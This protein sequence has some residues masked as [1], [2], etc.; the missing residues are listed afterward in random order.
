[1]KLTLNLALKADGKELIL[2]KRIKLLKEIDKTGSILQAAKN[3]P[4]SYKTAWDS[5]D[6]M[7]NLS[8]EVLVHSKAGGR[9]GGGTTLSEYGKNLI[10][11]Y[12]QIKEAQNS[13][14]KTLSE[15]V[16]LNSGEIENLERIAM[17]ISAR[18]VFTGK[19]KKITEGMVNAE[20]V[21]ELKD[22]V[23]ISSVITKNSVAN[24]E[25]E[26]GKEAKA[27]IKA[28]SVMFAT[29]SDIAISARN[30]IEGKIVKIT[31]GQVNAEVSIDIGS[32]QILTGVVTIN[33]VKRLGL[34]EGMTAYGVI[35]ST[36]VMIGL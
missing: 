24:L 11:V 8:S 31:D 14:L 33:S 13:F 16:N 3:V 27:I 17:Q 20:V 29:S 9:Q 34:K 18:N 7:N 2:D 6:L 26:V 25:L 30:I 36:E 4:M 15:S 1:M 35:K 21:L 28:T 5:V 23:E 19:V 22:G 10:L 32:E 12:D